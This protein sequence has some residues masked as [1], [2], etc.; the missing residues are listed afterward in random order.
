MSDL[1]RT[2]RQAL[3]GAASL[4]ALL[5][6]GPVDSVVDHLAGRVAGSTAAGVRRRVRQ[7]GA[8]PL[9][10]GRLLPIL[11]AALDGDHAHHRRRVRVA[12][13]IATDVGAS[14]RRA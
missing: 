9:G 1:V 13:G 14:H 3:T 6:A 10:V 11:V 2:H 8:E 5:T 7:H 12:H 4:T